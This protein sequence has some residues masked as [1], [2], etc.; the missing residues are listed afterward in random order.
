M[1]RPDEHHDGKPQV[2]CGSES[3][4]HR[5]NQRQHDQNK[6]SQDEDRQDLRLSR[7]EPPEPDRQ[8]R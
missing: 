4:Q 2:P 8:Q 7:N 5:R 1:T 3:D 6:S